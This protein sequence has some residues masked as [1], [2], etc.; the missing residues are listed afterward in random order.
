MN[1]LIGSVTT[2][3]ILALL[4]LGVF[5]SYRIYHSLDLT[6]DGSFGVGAAVV[7]TLLVR[8]VHPL[9]ATAIATLTGIIAGSITGILH[10]Q[11]FIS[12]LLA[13]VLISTAL[14]SVSLFVMGS[15]NVSL[16][17]AGSLMASAERL[18]QRLQDGALALLP[19]I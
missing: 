4:G 13:G 16:V 18:G 15:G 2:G 5:I 17:S 19:M 1:L 10:T 6:A 11:F 9:P 14:Y 12:T 8:E 3:L 7:A